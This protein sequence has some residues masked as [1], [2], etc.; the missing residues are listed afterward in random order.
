MNKKNQKLYVMII[1]LFSTLSFSGCVAL[2]VGAAAGAGSV[3][4][5]QGSLQQNFDHTIT[6]LHKAS[7]AAF[8]SL[9]IVKGDNELNRHSSY[10]KGVFEDGKKV[11]IDIQSLTERSSRLKIRVGL[12]G[13]KTI[14]QMILNAIN[15]KL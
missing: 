15:N 2:A 6:Q 11:K 8:K 7:L 14:S 3:G 5:A 13:D 12:F 10:I 4:Y 9:N 1:L